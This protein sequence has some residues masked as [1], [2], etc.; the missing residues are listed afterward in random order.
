M[1]NNVSR[2]IDQTYNPLGITQLGGCLL[3]NANC[4]INMMKKM[5][6]KGCGKKQRAGFPPFAA[7]LA[8]ATAVHKGLQK[9]KPF[10]KL[11]NALENNVKNK[12]SIIYKIPHTVASVASDFGYGKKKKRRSK[13]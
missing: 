10:S 6:K 12:D 9:F 8:G 1:K 7:I 3:P 5:H 13:K 4:S 11:K 2:S